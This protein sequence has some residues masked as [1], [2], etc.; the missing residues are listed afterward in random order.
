MQYHTPSIPSG[1]ACLAIMRASLVARSVFAGVT[2][3]MRQVSLQMS[4][5][6]MSLLYPLSYLQM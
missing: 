6:I 3:R 5:M 1:S 4:V 2:A